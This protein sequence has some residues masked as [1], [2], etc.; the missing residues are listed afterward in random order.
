M[1]Y[2]IANAD[3]A[4]NYGIVTDGHYH[5]EGKV[6]LNEKEV[7][8]CPYIREAESL[9]DRAKIL[10]AEIYDIISIKQKIRKGDWKI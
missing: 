8:T 2:L 9:E 5:S 1:R 7:M 4:K 3:Q 10:E 6:I